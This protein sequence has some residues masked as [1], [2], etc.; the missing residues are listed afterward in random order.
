MPHGT[1]RD[2]SK[3]PRFNMK[4]YQLY[5]KPIK[6]LDLG[7]SGGGFVKECIDDGNFAIG[8][9]GSDYSKRMKRAEWRTIPEYLYTCDITR[10]F[11]LYE[12]NSR[13]KF[14][15][16]TAWEVLEHINEKDLKVLINN[17]KKHLSDD[18]LIIT[19]VA[20]K[21]DIINGVELHQTQKPKK[22]WIN[23]FSKEGLKYMP[24]YIQYFNTQYIRY[25]Y[26][27]AEQFHLI[28]A[29]IDANPPVPPKEPILS[30]VFDR[31]KGSRIQNILSEA[32]TN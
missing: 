21:S 1:R 12:N 25:K 8:L 6:I 18:G 5:K 9:E 27:T 32:L 20:N 13:I 19:S 23:R 26:E 14:N 4:L 15:I 30:R 16:I 29:R 2:N 24:K 11:D 3:N 17:M 28:F 22:W 31:W 10:N 7:C